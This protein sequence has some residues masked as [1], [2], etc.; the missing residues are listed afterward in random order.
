LTFD[1]ATRL[2]T[3]NINKSEVPN[4]IHPK[5]LSEN[6]EILA[7][8]LKIIFEKSFILKHYL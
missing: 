2:N 7:Y 3:L 1:I 8:P 4:G 5:V 6:A